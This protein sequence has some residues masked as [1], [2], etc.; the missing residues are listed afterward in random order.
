MAGPSTYRPTGWRCP[1]CDD[2][3]RDAELVVR[4]YWD[5]KYCVLFCLD[6]GSGWNLDRSAGSVGNHHLGAIRRGMTKTKHPHPTRGYF[7]PL[8][9]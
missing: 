2:D 7:G 3:G 6:C 5:A 1:Q 4:W 9:W 8:V